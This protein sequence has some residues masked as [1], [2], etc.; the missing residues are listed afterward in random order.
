MRLD[1]LVVVEGFHPQVGQVRFFGMVD[2]VAKVHEGES[3]DT[4][5]FLAVEGKIPVSL[6]YVA[7]VSVTR[8]L[9]EE[10]FPPDPGSPVYLAQEEDLELALYYDAMRNQ[11]GSTKLPAGLLKNG[12]V[13]YLNLEFL[14]G[15]KGGHVNISGISGVAAKTSY[16]TFLLKSLLESGVLE[17]AHQARVLLFNVKGRTSSSWT[18]PT[19]ASPRRRGRPTRGLASPRPPSRA[20]PSSPRPRR[21]ATSRT[22]T[23]GW[24]GWRP[25]TGTWSSSARGASSPSSSPT[26]PP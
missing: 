15:V 3:F 5:T 6:A 9:P 19:P 7:H 12:E 24:R 21:R 10:F 1:D 4:D 20:W 13:A 22:W 26:A 2:H 14:N 23:P 11:R 8:I 16:A 18:S 25:T 17:D